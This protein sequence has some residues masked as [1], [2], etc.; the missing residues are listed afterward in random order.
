MRPLCISL[1][2]L[3]EQVLF[4]PQRVITV[5]SGK[6]EVNGAVAGLHTAVSVPRDSRGM[7]GVCLKCHREGKKEG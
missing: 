7:L 6:G 5:P 4:S 1:E 2:L 3:A